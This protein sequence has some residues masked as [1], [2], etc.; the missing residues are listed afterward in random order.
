MT[1]TVEPAALS[2]E[3]TIA[4]ALISGLAATI[5]PLVIQPYY[6]H[7]K[8]LYDRTRKHLDSLVKLE[9]R[10]LDIDATLHDNKIMFNFVVEGYKKHQ[11]S[12]QRLI[13]LE[14]EDSFM[15][16]SFSGELN[17]KIYQFRYD[18][19]RINNDIANF[20][21]NYDMLAKAVLLD[22]MKSS[23]VAEKL[24]GL[25]VD[26]DKMEEGLEQLQI[27]CQRLL[28][29]SKLRAKKDRVL[30]IKYR[31]W[32]IQRR[33]KKITEEEVNAEVESYRKKVLENADD[34]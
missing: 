14:L 29:Y 28:A 9:L 11:V 32:I 34:K 19:R 27:D 7:R 21:Y 3:A 30:L 23:Q 5:I 22:E 13:P 12:I 10:L 20:N 18:L 24:G 1:N 31:S 15:T 25:L 2:L 33:L 26:K 16:D 6:S 4:I 8:R 17:N